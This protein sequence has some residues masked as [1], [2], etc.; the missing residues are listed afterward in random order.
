MQY[1]TPAVL[2]AASL[3]FS[4]PCLAVRLNSATVQAFDRYIHAA[5]TRIDSRLRAHDL[6]ADDSPGRL[7][8]LRSGQIVAEPL[9]G[10]GDADLAGALIHD[11]IGAIFVP[12]A[13]L[14]QTLATLQ[15]YDRNKETHK[16]E[17]LDSKI[18]SRNGNDFHVYLRLMKKK[19]I[20]VVLDTEHDIR[21]FPVEGSFC[22]SRSYSTRIAEVDN[23]GKRDERELPVGND[24]GYLWR[25]YSYWRFEEKDGGVYI[26][27]EAISLTRDVPLGLGW[28]IEPIIRTM[29]QESLI[30]TLR[31]SRDA[32]LG[33]PA[34]TPV[35]RYFGGSSLVFS[36]GSG[37]G[38]SNVMLASALNFR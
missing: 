38:V 9:I 36:S 12:H 30:N 19:V 37:S 25:L 4:A 7:N 26:E 24:H 28:L 11:W 27:C 33:R 3:V 6:W 29:P 16:P 20:T 22:H 32:I 31:S 34:P 18:L 14:R 35:S 2:A 21:Y 8:R 17:V 5:E 15:D 13:T 1:R 23:P 10:Q